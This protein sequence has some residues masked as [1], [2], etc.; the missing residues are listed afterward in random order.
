MYLATAS[1]LIGIM[2]VSR[3]THIAG[4]F[5]GRHLYHRNI[6]HLDNKAW[7]ASNARTRRAYYLII[8]VSSH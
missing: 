7:A 6:Y 5:T 2:A 8:N 4:G 3:N 1:T